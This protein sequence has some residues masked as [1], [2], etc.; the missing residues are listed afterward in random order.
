[1][2]VRL[3]YREKECDLQAP[4]PAHAQTLADD[5]GLATLFDAMAAGDE[6]VA[7]VARRTLL[8]A[9]DTDYH[10][11]RYRQ[12]VVR[13]CLANDATVRRV[14]QLA[15]EAIEA[16]RKSLWFGSNRHAS[17]SSM[18]YWSVQSL[19]L[20]MQY[21]REIRHAAE[22]HAGA[23]ASEG[24]VRLWAMLREELSD[25]YLAEVK[26]QLKNL[27]FRHGVCMSAGLDAGSVGVKYVLHPPP[28]GE[29]AWWKVIWEWWWRRQSE[30]TY[31]VADRDEAG[32]RVLAE[33]RNR[34]LAPAAQATAGAVTH[35]VGFFTQ[36]RTELAFYIGCSNLHRRLTEK[37]IAVCMPEIMVDGS[38][39]ACDELRDVCLALLQ[40]Q[41][42]IGNSVA[43]DGKWLVLITSANQ[44]GKTTFLRAVGLAQ[45]M[46]QSGMFVA[47]RAF[48]SS[49]C[50]GMFTHY[51]REE[52]AS[53]V[54]GK[55][56]EELRRMSA[57]VEIMQPGALALLNEPFAATNEREG[58]EIAVQ[59]VRA[60][61]DAGVRVFMVTHLYECARYFWQEHGAN[62]ISLRAGRD[63]DGRRMFK[64]VPDAP[65]PTSFGA[66]LYDQVFSSAHKET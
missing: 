12:A 33:I 49:V 42:V 39:F 64:L 2:K 9:P 20:L 48:R 24:F 66:D 7:R 35:I 40:R 18:L 41:P 50:R 32:S 44:G 11:A 6:L 63:E 60:L 29:H 19:N 17:S 62:I 45:L 51:K 58:S 13:D 43:A 31:R 23:F 25:A 5:L 30:W 1:M 22:A 14:Y 53:M 10:T 27:R 46:M 8:S 52:D 34:G 47:A 16:N 15:I 3:L 38:A 61:C 57:I 36:L 65:R 54:S 26:K 55:C 59:V 21:L 4:L 56:D 28:A 37:N